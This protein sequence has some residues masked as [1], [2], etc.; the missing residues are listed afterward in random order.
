MKYILDTH[1]EHIVDLWFTN[2]LYQASETYCAMIICLCEIINLQMGYENRQK[3]LPCKLS[4]LRHMYID[5]F[6]EVTFNVRITVS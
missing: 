5:I 1:L 3:S 6:T 4:E 2:T